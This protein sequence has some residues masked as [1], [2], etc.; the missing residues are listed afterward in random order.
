VPKLS[1][2][3]EDAE[4]A[5][6]IGHLFSSQFYYYFMVWR[7]AH[8]VVGNDSDI[9]NMLSIGA[10]EVWFCVCHATAAAHT[11]CSGPKT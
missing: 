3:Q 5:A 7:I 9:A 4:A 6:A 11:V 1:R 8:Y 2:P 10:N